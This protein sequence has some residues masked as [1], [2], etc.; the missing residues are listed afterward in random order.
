MNRPWLALKVGV[1]A[2]PCGRKGRW[3]SIRS[4]GLAGLL[5][6]LAWNVS[7]SAWAFQAAGTNGSGEGAIHAVTDPPGAGILMDG[8]FVGVTPARFAWEPGTH[9]LELKKYG[10]HDLVLD[11]QVVRG[12]RMEVDLKL[13]PQQPTRPQGSPL[14]DRFGVS[15]PS[16]SASGES[17]RLVDAPVHAPSIPVR[18]VPPVG[19]SVP[20]ETAK[21]SAWVV[22]PGQGD[23]LS[24]RKSEGD[25]KDRDSGRVYT[26][27][28]GGSQKITGRVQEMTRSEMPFRY[29]IQVGA[30][31][32][33]ESALKQA[34]LWRRKGYDAYLLELYGIKDPSRLWQSVRI[35]RFDS[36][37]EARRFLDDFHAREKSDGYVAMSDSFAPPTQAP[38]VVQGKESRTPFPEPGEIKEAQASG[39]TGI[40][41]AKSFAPGAKEAGAA[42]GGDSAFGKMPPSS[43]Q[44]V[45]TAG[46]ADTGPALA[47]SGAMDRAAT[48]N[49]PGPEMTG[50]AAMPAVV[51][52]SEPGKAESGKAES[53]KGLELGPVVLSSEDGRPKVGIGEIMDKGT[54]GPSTGSTPVMDLKVDLARTADHSVALGDVAAGQGTGGGKEPSGEKDQVPARPE[55]VAAVGD[56][57]QDGANG[58]AS[59]GQALYDQANEA[60]NK[61][62][63]SSAMEL[64]RRALE[65]D[66]NHLL[67]RQRLARIHVEGG[68][69]AEALAVL[70]PAVA[71]RDSRG[72]AN[73]DP[74]FSAFL[75]ALYQRQEE[76]WKAVDLYEA[77]LR[78]HPER[79]IWQ[80]G[81]AIS[82]E[83][84]NEPANALR[85]YEKALASGDLSS[86]L[87]GFVQKRI[88]NLR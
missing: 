61:G 32:D 39:E 51:P 17:A 6:L 76:H 42:A 45:A 75:A 58:G 77:L 78:I 11:L 14:M 72:L 37:I 31:L 24:S 4:W 46:V 15:D 79:G 80:M 35:G 27:E 66:P 54:A 57:S 34:A 49:R 33:R 20:S 60:E 85:Y 1:A 3:S 43:S 48:P 7:G 67:A 29:S 21:P 8:H 19:T 59:E 82:L 47:S 86:R 73:A 41:V 65:R 30:F 2:D 40:P 26:V 87:R 62:N 83:K 38:I 5:A 18:Q 44:T 28:E 74:N 71:G 10:Y 55:K 50:G 36:I 68:R 81:M 53:G 25:A 69:P 13:Y 84:L 52:V 23:S 64:Y 56:T 9:R 12:R 16:V 70:K 63:V 88:R 22:Q